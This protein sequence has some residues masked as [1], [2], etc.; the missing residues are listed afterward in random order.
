MLVTV[1]VVPQ[2]KQELLTQEVEV[3]V[4]ELSQVKQ[5]YQDLVAQASP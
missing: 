4:E 5:V 3:E 1:E 2:H